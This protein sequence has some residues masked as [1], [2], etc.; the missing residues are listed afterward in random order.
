LSSTF[1]ADENLMKEFVLKGFDKKHPLY[2]EYEYEQDDLVPD[3]DEEFTQE[4][5]LRT[6]AYPELNNI[7][8][9][10]EEFKSQLGRI[11]GLFN[12]LPMDEIETL[13][14]ESDIE[15]LHENLSLLSSLEFWFNKLQNISK[16][17]QP[18]VAHNNNRINTAGIFDFFK[19]RTKQQDR[20]KRN[21]KQEYGDE[22]A[23]L[24]TITR[25]LASAVMAIDP[26]QTRGNMVL[27]D[28]KINKIKDNIY[29]IV[30][31]MDNNIK[32]LAK[33]LDMSLL[34]LETKE[35]P[36]G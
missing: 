34:P 32:G 21:M 3:T 35:M 20:L 10:L 15:N 1:S 24:N 18:L 12:Q 9:N 28:D 26:S 7:S 11:L 4:D 23:S 19:G 13:G 6:E 25:N 36:T 27:P 30:K 22:L 16:T 14:L 33:S 29:N 31:K 8:Y 2:P 17:D 5:P